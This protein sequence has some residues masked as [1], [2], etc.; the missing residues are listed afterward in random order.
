MTDVFTTPEGHRIAYKKR[1]GSGPGVLFLHG[2]HSDMNGDKAEA[3]D[4]WAAE[5]GRAFL[6]FD[7]SGHG[8]SSEAYPDT[9]IADW[10]AD[11]KAVLNDLAEGPQVLVGSSMGGW[12]ALLLA[13]EFPEKVAA[14]V[15]VAAAPDFT[16]DGY[17]ASFTEE[18]KTLLMEQGYV[19]L[20]YGPQPYRIMKKFIVDGRDH[21]VMR[22]P[23][24]LKMPVRL[25]QGS[26]DRSVPP[27]WAVKLFHHADGRNIR[28]TMV[29]GADHRFSAPENIELI[30]ATLDEVLA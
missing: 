4:A 24:P 8:E 14:L 1:A 5:K 25:L 17:F 13:R 7:C 27:D 3:L 29:K 23:L 20:Q 16:E 11:A 28:L 10:Y 22:D 19:D 30:K 21:F 15:T 9:S 26:E 2:L 12:L 18:Q 6:R